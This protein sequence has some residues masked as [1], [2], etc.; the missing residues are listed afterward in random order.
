M[1]CPTLSCPIHYYCTLYYYVRLTL[2]CIILLYH[3]LLSPS[4]LSTSVPSYSRS[5]V[6]Y[7]RPLISLL[8]PPFSYHL[9]PSSHSPPS[10]LTLSL[11]TPF[12]HSPSF[13]H[14]PPPYRALP[15]H[16][17][18]AQSA[19]TLFWHFTGTSSNTHTH[20]HLTQMSR[21]KYT[22]FTA[23]YC[24]VLHYTALHFNFYTRFAHERAI[25][26]HTTLQH[27][28]DSKCNRV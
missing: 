2:Y 12:P 21:R 23:L 10:L 8:S 22:Y 5:S 9:H 24:I 11:L 26:C 17:R 28:V 18:G 15:G 6:I 13:P 1:S 4:S 25:E 19:H 16:E 14:S 27:L 7:V 20:T 3:V